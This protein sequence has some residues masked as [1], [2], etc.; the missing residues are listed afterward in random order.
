MGRT[1]TA[2]VGRTTATALTLQ[3]SDSVPTPPW[4]AH[5]GHPGSPGSK[6]RVSEV[7][8]GGD[9]VPKV[10]QVPP[11]SS[12]H[13]ELRV[14]PRH[15]TG[16]PEARTRCPA[17]HAGPNGPGAEPLSWKFFPPQPG[18]VLGL[19]VLTRSTTRPFPPPGEPPSGL[20]IGPG[21]RQP[22]HADLARKAVQWAAR[23]LRDR[24]LGRLGHS[25][26]LRRW[27]VRVCWTRPQAC[28]REHLGREGVCEKRAGSWFRGL[29]APVGQGFGGSGPGVSGVP[30]YTLSPSN[31]G[32]PG[33]EFQQRV[34]PSPQ[35]PETRGPRC[36]WPREGCSGTSVRRAVHVR[37]LRKVGP[38]TLIPLKP[39]D[40]V[41]SQT[42]L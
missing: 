9:W 18:D 8:L 36:H 27:I 29:S 15:S 20:G 21:M 41:G 34:G 23:H 7:K 19:R 42:P 12:G 6:V 5:T 10:S 25:V 4:T 31:A 28:H 17:P 22:R 30:E 11:G 14:K 35:G 2:P 40:A 26:S 1:L 33:H 24:C 16:R 3:C 13:T 37:N 38:N 39:R 32:A